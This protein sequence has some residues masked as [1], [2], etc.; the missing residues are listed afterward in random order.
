MDFQPSVVCH[1]AFGGSIDSAE[2][3]L[4]G[5]IECV[6]S[7]VR[8]VSHPVSPSLAIRAGFCGGD[9]AATAE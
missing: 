2:G 1:F 5:P 8:T 3:P 9:Y 7:T 6:G 4:R